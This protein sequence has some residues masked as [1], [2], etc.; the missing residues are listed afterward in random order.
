MTTFTSRFRSQDDGGA[1]TSWLLIFTPVILIVVGLLLDGGAQIAARQDALGAA[2]LASRSAL[3]ALSGEEWR[4]GVLPPSHIMTNR[5]CAGVH[6][7]Y[8]SHVDRCQATVVSRQE[9]VVDV[10]LSHSTKF[11][12][13]VG[14]NRVSSTASK[15]AH[16][17]SGN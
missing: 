9:I 6:A 5:A 4:A 14:I 1:L 2:R 13:V 15:T 10:R 8:G 11:L 16:A 3:D 17:E 7:Q 12:R